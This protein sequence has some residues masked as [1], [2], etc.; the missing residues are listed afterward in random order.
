VWEA[1]IVSRQSNT[2]VRQ[3]MLPQLT[4]KCQR[5]TSRRM[6]GATDSQCVPYKEPWANLFPIYFETLPVG[7]QAG[8]TP[9]RLD[10]AGRAIVI[11]LTG[12]K[13]FSGDDS[14]SL[15]ISHLSAIRR[16]RQIPSGWQ[17]HS[18]SCAKNCSVTVACNQ[19]NKLTHSFHVTKPHPLI[20]SD[21]HGIC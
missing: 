12:H 17:S 19:K 4:Q 11:L 9:G 15:R 21:W 2:T 8:V 18:I 20:T 16:R 3:M 7:A 6:A 5:K 13:E 10:T 14:L 1:I